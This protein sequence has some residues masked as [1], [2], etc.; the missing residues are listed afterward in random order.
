ML[1]YANLVITVLVISSCGGGG[2][3]GGTTG[4]SANSPVVSN[5]Q[6][7]P[8]TAERTGIT[9]AYR[10]TATVTDPNNDLVGGTER[11][12]EPATGDVTEFTILA[13]VDT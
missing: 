2:G 9:L 13:S 11:F 6:I 8:L 12:R 10:V 3:G 7:R 1:R 5:F 4:P